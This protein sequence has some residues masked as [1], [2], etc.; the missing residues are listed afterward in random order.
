MNQWAIRRK[1]I[2]LSLVLAVLILLIGV[3]LFFLFYRAPTCDD[4][5]RNGDETGVDC[6]GSC[7]LL[8][9]VESLPPVQSG[10]PQVL[11]VATSTYEVVALF[12]NPNTEAEVYRAGYTIKLYESANSVP[13]KTI[14][15][16]TY[17]PKNKTFA[18]F[19]GP[20]LLEEAIPQTAI[21]NWKNESL[22]WQKT[23]REAPAVTIQNKQFTKET[24]APRL[25][26][27][28]ENS[29]LKSVNNLEL[30]VLVSDETGNIFAGSRTFVNSLAPGQLTPVVFSWPQAFESKVS[31][32][33][34]ITRSL[35][36]KSFIR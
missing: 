27:I 25:E 7:Q 12:D 32:I 5:K 30:I 19:E 36:D 6:G 11:T 17:I 1:R 4:G 16:E 9:A 23:E 33:D 26:I 15:G 34:V 8:C 3:P 18:I 20:F 13:V 31:G 22:I 14:E 28:V 24:V 29:S 10:D 2:I 35:P 21:F